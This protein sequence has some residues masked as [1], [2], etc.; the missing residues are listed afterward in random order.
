MQLD[1]GSVNRIGVIVV[2]EVRGALPPFA[3]FLIL[4]HRIALITT[5]LRWNG[6]SKPSCVESGADA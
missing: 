4:F 5:M 6:N 1:G 3:F 2:K